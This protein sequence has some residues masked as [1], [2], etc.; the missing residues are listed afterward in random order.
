MF[1]SQNWL[2]FIQQKVSENS[3]FS[4]KWSVLAQLVE[5][6]L[7]YEVSIELLALFMDDSFL[8]SYN[9]NEIFIQ[10][11]YPL[12]PRLNLI[13]VLQILYKLIPAIGTNPDHFQEYMQL[14]ERFGAETESL[15]TDCLI[16]KEA[17]TD[18]ASTHSTSAPSASARHAETLTDETLYYFLCKIFLML[19][20]NA[21]F[22][23][24]V[25]LDDLHA[26]LHHVRLRM[27]DNSKVMLP[28]LRLKTYYVLSLYYQYIE[29]FEKYYKSCLTFLYSMQSKMSTVAPH[30][31]AVADAG[32]DQSQTKLLSSEQLN[33]RPEELLSVCKSACF[34]AL[35]A[36][37]LFSFG[38]L[39]GHPLC[40]H[41]LSSAADSSWIVGLIEAFNS[42]NIPTF[43]TTCADNQHLLDTEAHFLSK[44]RDVLRQKICMMAFLNLA[45]N[46]GFKHLT[47]HQI[48]QHTKVSP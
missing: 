20:G 48:T 35:V 46:T 33:I 31:P 29:D 1:S 9:P 41:L 14:F 45:Y 42:G 22:G 8:S 19:H 5:K 12:K 10:L 24:A 27:N 23:I 4:S 17:C 11:V 6:K 36:K 2:N 43:E 37:N 21:K 44:H 38:E 32:D 34:A 16:S 26:I 18:G 13:C 15:D 28:F 47:F 25:C 7:W 40:E 3:T 39:L 30:N